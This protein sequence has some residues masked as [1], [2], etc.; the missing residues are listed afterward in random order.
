MRT[1]TT[2]LE[3]AQKSGGATFTKIVLTPPAAGDDLTYLNSSYGTTPNIILKTVWTEEGELQSAIVVLDNRNSELDDINFD[4][5]KG[6]ISSG[7]KGTAGIEYSAKAPLWVTSQHEITNVKQKTLAVQLNLKGVFNWWQDLPPEGDA[8]TVKEI[9]MVIANPALS[10]TGAYPTIASFSHCTGTGGAS[11]AYTIDWDD[12]D[13]LADTVTPA[14]SFRITRG[15]SR[16]DVWK[17]CLTY[18]DGVSRIEADGHIHIFKASSGTA[19]TVIL[20]PNAV[21]DETNI[22]EEVSTGA[23]HWSVVDEVIADELTTYLMEGTIAS[24]K[25][26]LYKIG[27]TA[28]SG[29]ISGITVTARCAIGGANPPDRKSMKIT[30]KT[31]GTVYEGDEETLSEVAWANFTKAWATNPQTGKAWTFI[32]IA[33]LQIGISM[34]NGHSSTSTVKSVCT[35]IFVTVSYTSTN[36]VYA[37]TAGS[38]PF[39]D[40]GYQRRLVNPNKIVVDSL[41]TDD[42]KY[43]GSATSATDYAKMPVTRYYEMHLVSDAQAV[44]I[45]TAIQKRFT[46]E[47]ESGNGNVPPNVGQ[48]MWDY[49]AIVDLFDGQTRYGNVGYIQ[50]TITQT[51]RGMY[52]SFG[53]PILG[54][55]LDIYGSLTG[56]PGE[57]TTSSLKSEIDN[58][59]RYLSMAFNQDNVTEILP[60]RMVYSKTHEL[61]NYTFTPNDPDTNNFKWEDVVLVYKGTAYNI[62]DGNTKITGPPV[63]NNKYVWWDYSG[64][65][66]VFQVSVTRPTLEAGDCLVAY[67]ES[68]VPLIIT[69]ETLLSGGVLTTG[70]IVADLLE[71]RLVLAT[72]VIAGTEGGDRVELSSAGLLCVG[73]YIKLWNNQTGGGSK[74]GYIE[75]LV[76]DSSMVIT[77]P[78]A[79]LILS[80]GGS[81]V[82]GNDVIPQTP[83]GN[84]LG[85]ATALWGT[86]YCTYLGDATHYITTAY[87]TTINATTINITTILPTHV[88]SSGSYV[89]DAF[90][91]T[92]YS[93]GNTGQTV[94][95]AGM[96][97]TDSIGGGNWHLHFDGGILTTAT[98]T[99]PP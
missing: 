73:Q 24:Y 54:G 80:S 97:F 58:I 60:A 2:T 1:L 33:S 28:V 89:T 52:L 46:L 25:R 90:V 59:Y 50:E 23:A 93:N 11:S 92:Y 65:K 78:A 6:V 21:G 66:G 27:S 10:G 83:G 37:L 61:Q 62:T 69:Q 68:G 13:A 96:D 53:K 19:S 81:I 17:K 34:R 32:D 57:I 48:E 70:S 26:D 40:K 91:T 45:A 29:I 82:C 72:T 35:Q 94:A 88:G 5:Y 77:A 31:G 12:E 44:A 22:T 9:M 4:A 85:L 76:S 7:A 56:K 39:F 86:V 74:F 98:Y 64:D 20:R 51:E 49:V 41:S 3:A 47:A 8:Y 67:N 36:Y 63:V 55:N 43:T 14:N 95:G 38:H 84:D 30:M 79:G 87:I 71:T 16:Y 15:D 18:F 75:L 99:P 42:V